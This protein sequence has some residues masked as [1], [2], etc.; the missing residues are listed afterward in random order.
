MEGLNISQRGGGSNSNLGVQIVN[1][2]IVID[3]FMNYYTYDL[4]KWVGS[5]TLLPFIPT[6]TTP[7]FQNSLNSV[8]ADV[9]LKPHNVRWR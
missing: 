8:N 2:R 9:T 3:T 4:E 6:S 5:C 7:V 1:I